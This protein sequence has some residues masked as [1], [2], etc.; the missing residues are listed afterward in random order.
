MKLTDTIIIDAI[1]SGKT[2]IVF[3]NGEIVKDNR[4]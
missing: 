3:E 2:G 4:E 1:K